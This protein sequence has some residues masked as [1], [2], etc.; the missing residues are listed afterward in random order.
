M[1]VAKG[2]R[3]R[4]FPEV[5][6]ATPRRPKFAQRPF[7][8]LPMSQGGPSRAGL[9]PRLG[10][11]LARG[12]LDS[13]WRG[14]EL[15]STANYIILELF[16]I[17]FLDFL[18]PRVPR[19]WWHEVLFGAPLPHAPGVRMTVVTLT[20]SNKVSIPG[21]RCLV[22]GNSYMVHAGRLPETILG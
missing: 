19:K 22:P 4:R 6:F 2:Q 12:R 21:A 17:H 8:T 10:Q 1:P 5:K 13:F 16:G 11:A 3:R 9:E 14:S 7:Q 18:V 15:S 20:P